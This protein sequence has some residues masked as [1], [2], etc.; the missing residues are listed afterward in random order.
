MLG[1]C[2]GGGSSDSSPASGSGMLYLNLTDS[3]TGEYKAIYVTIDTVQVHKD[4]G[5][6]WKTISSPRRT[7]NLLHLVNG[8]RESLGLV[9]LEIGRYAQM[10]LILGNRPDGVA[11]L[12]S[13]THPYANY[14]ISAGNE[15]VELKIPGGFQTGI[16]IVQGF[17]IAVNQTTE[18]L[19]DFD[20]ARSVVK[21]GTT[22]KWLLKPT[23]KILDTR[24]YSIVF[25]TVKDGGATPKGVPG[26]VVSAQNYDPAGPDEGESVVT[27]AATIT[28]E[29]GSFKLFLKPG[30]YMIVACGEGFSPSARDVSTQAGTAQEVNFLVAAA[31]TGNLNLSVSIAGANEE[32]VALISVRQEVNNE[33]I[34]IKSFHLANQNAAVTVLPAGSYI[35][36]TSTSG[37]STQTAKAIVTAGQTTVVPA[38]AF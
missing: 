18:L 5:D 36:V 4:G 13:H 15:A 37:R 12:L 6:A 9:S 33:Q 27:E 19:L 23:I 3:A 21:A 14:F 26:A 32:Q 30:S 25:G 16:K 20:A 34:E 31:A 24:D 1:A 29:N 7:V 28:D 35:V 38:F 22:G 10:R 2:G 11:N 8:V 17:D